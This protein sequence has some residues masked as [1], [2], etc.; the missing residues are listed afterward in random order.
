MKTMKKK[1]QYLHALHG[2]NKNPH[3]FK[4]NYYIYQALPYNSIN[5]FIFLGKTT[6]T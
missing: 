6:E 2:K 1:L 3:T 4:Y 5:L